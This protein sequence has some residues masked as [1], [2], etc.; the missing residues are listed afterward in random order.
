MF[1]IDVGDVEWTALCFCD[2]CCVRCVGSFLAGSAGIWF[3]CSK[4]SLVLG[5]VGKL[6][7]RSSHGEGRAF[8]FG[9]VDDPHVVCFSLL[10]VAGSS[11]GTVLHAV[12]G[13]TV[14]SLF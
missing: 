9:V 8:G 11:S 10:L 4:V 6:C 13:V 3:S 2:L 7:S 14:F 5:F 1:S 12:V